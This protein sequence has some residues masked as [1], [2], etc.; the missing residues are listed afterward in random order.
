[1]EERINTY[2]SR[3]NSFLDHFGY[4]EEKPLEE[5]DFSSFMEKASET[6]PGAYQRLEQLA[7][8]EKEDKWDQF[9]DSTPFFTATLPTAIP[10][11]VVEHY[12]RKGQRYS[13]FVAAAIVGGIETLAFVKGIPLF[14]DDELKTLQIQHALFMWTNLSLIGMGLRWGY[15][16][17]KAREEGTQHF[18]EEGNEYDKLQKRITFDILSAVTK[19]FNPK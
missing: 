10:W 19:H 1:M 6:W 7:Q 14:C 11:K 13:G 12:A 2:Y 17:Q 16:K 18:A 15:K 4:T 9:F 3:L 5:K 8:E